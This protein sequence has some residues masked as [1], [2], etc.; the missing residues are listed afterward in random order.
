[1]SPRDTN[2]CADCGSPVHPMRCYTVF[3]PVQRRPD[4][5]P[6]PSFDGAKFKMCEKCWDKMVGNAVM[7]MLR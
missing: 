3:V 5:T 4:Y 1:M 2:T 7:G 6:N